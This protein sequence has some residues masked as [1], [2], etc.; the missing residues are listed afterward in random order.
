MVSCLVGAVQVRCA[1]RRPPVT[2]FP[3]R[4]PRGILAP[5]NLAENRRGSPPHG[6][7]PEHHELVVIEPTEG[8][9]RKFWTGLL[10]GPP[11]EW[12]LLCPGL[13][14]SAGRLLRKWCSVKPPPSPSARDYQLVSR[15]GVAVILWIDRSAPLYSCS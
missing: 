9:D 11:G 12:R 14:D 15:S 10:P 7:S 6:N 2:A 13:H 3:R 8:I 5:T 1:G 4:I